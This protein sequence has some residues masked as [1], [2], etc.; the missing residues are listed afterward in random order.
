MTPFFS[1]WLASNSSR[2]AFPSFPMSAWLAASAPAT[3]VKQ[4]L[5]VNS[6]LFTA[7]TDNVRE[8]RADSITQAGIIGGQL[9]FLQDVDVVI[10]SD[11]GGLGVNEVIVHFVSASGLEHL[12]ARSF[13]ADA[14]GD[15][16]RVHRLVA[17]PH[18]AQ[19]ALK[20]HVGGV[21]L[22]LEFCAR[23]SEGPRAANSLGI[24]GH[25]LSNQRFHLGV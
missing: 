25:R 5:L 21:I 14:R 17:C 20:K 13:E 23:A 2:I 7:F 11:G 16:H 24:D 9:L 15:L 12:P 3:A 1:F 22:Q 18:L 19:A 4:V 10:Q 6:M 8:M